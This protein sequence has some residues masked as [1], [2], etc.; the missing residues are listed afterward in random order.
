MIFISL[1]VKRVIIVCP[2]LMNVFFSVWHDEAFFP[3]CCADDMCSVLWV[4]ELF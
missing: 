1:S 2:F 4:A 3:A